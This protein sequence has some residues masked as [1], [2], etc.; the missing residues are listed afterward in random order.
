MFRPV[1]EE[2]AGRWIQLY[3]EEFYHLYSSPDM[4]KMLRLQRR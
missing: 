3:N 4:I 2:A 1:R